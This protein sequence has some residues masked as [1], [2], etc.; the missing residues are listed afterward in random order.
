MNSYNPGAAPNPDPYVPIT[1]VANLFYA[2]SSSTDVQTM[3]TALLTPATYGNCG[4]VGCYLIVSSQGGMGFTSCPGQDSLATNCGQKAQPGGLFAQLGGTISSS[5]APPSAAYS[6]VTTISTASSSKVPLFPPSGSA[7]ESL[8]CTLTAG[9][10]PGLTTCPSRSTN[11]AV[12][13]VFVNYLPATSA[14]LTFTTTNPISITARSVNA[15]TGV[16]TVTVGSQQYQSNPL[17]ASLQHP[18]FQLVALD[19]GTLQLLANG[20]YYA[21]ANPGDNDDLSD[22][23]SQINSTALATE[24]VIW[25]I[26]SIGQV[27]NTDPGMYALSQAIATL[28][29]SFSV[30]NQL[31]AEPPGVT[32]CTTASD[33]ALIGWQQP[34][35]AATGLA[36]G[37][38]LEKSGGV[39]CQTAGPTSGPA[40][41]V[42]QQALLK[43][44]IRSFYTPKT[45][46]GAAGASGL[47]AAVLQQATSSWPPA[48][49]AQ[50]TASCPFAAENSPAGTPPTAGQAA[51]YTYL[52]QVIQAGP[53]SGFADLPPTPPVLPDIRQYYSQ[54]VT[55]SET[56]STGGDTGYWAGYLSA[57]T[58]PPNNYFTCQD[59]NG[60]QAELT[61]ELT[62]LNTIAGYTNTMY[63]AFAAALSDETLQYQQMYNL[64]E[65]SV[66]PGDGTSMTANVLSYLGTFL[67]DLLPI[68][69]PG[70]GDVIGPGLDAVTQ[71]I[72][73][74]I[75]L[76][77]A[78]NGAPGATLA[79]T[80]GALQNNLG[81]AMTGA[82]DGLVTGMQLAVTDPTR[83][84]QT[85]TAIGQFNSVDFPAYGGPAS[86]GSVAAQISSGLAA[87]ALGSLVGSTYSSVTLQ[88]LYGNITNQKPPD[89]T[90]QAYP[91]VALSPGKSIHRAVC[92]GNGSCLA[93]RQ[94]HGYAQAQA[95][96]MTLSN[97]PQPSQ[98]AG[99][100]FWQTSFMYL[101]GSCYPPNCDLYFPSQNV[102]AILFDQVNTPVSSPS[103][104]DPKYTVSALGLWPAYVL[105][106]GGAIPVSPQSTDSNF[107]CTVTTND[108]QE[109][110]SPDLSQPGP[111]T[112]PKP[113]SPAPTSSTLNSSAPPASPSAPPVIAAPTPQN[114]GL[115]GT[116]LPLNPWW[117]VAAAALLIALGAAALT[118]AR[119]RSRQDTS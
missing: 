101:N 3:Q 11:G 88:A 81:T 102:L 59:F 52:S 41:S 105:G 54:V 75:D 71:T 89:V 33:Y 68:V 56:S 73:F 103:A 21:Y 107:I 17:V 64:V 63:T 43:P 106:P 8:G 24:N 48:A 31:G 4:G 45:S 38:G 108:P 42:T 16:N 111:P 60:V 10:K 85:A 96:P 29:G 20:T 90:T 9:A 92:Q 15:T 49:A 110:C 97:Q 55:D 12:N 113:T 58:Y 25:V 84:N 115:A 50:A 2:V 5:Y 99:F 44:D 67:G 118:A 72:S 23:V 80:W 30:F 117:L 34:D 19:R 35:Q 13:G 47:Q 116:G 65:S 28:G 91:S 46:S 77:I 61:A 114:S 87:T 93:E 62:S 40:S 66:N 39:L 36:P 6:L 22:M 79:T 57:A 37:A 26:A 14:S 83:L 78:P 104:K 53:Q 82:Q 100:F 27:H 112:S 7:T 1:Q 86:S 109:Q 98:G 76:S 32:G 94:G 51:A 70:V 95:Y 18:G 69:V 119:H 74:G